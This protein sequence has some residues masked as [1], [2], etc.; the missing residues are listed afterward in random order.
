MKRVITED[1]YF[2]NFGDDEV[3]FILEND[4][5][6]ESK[7]K[8]SQM[9]LTGDS[10]K[11]STVRKSLITWIDPWKPP[12][13]V[14]SPLYRIIS[15]ANDAVWKYDLKGEW[16]GHIQYTKYIEKG[17]HYSWHQD[18]FRD[19]ED[20]DRKLSIVYSLCHTKDYKGGEFDLRQSND[21]V[22]SVK[23][24]YGDFI[25]FPSTIVHRVRPLRSGNR[26]TLVGWF[27]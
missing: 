4:A 20:T 22:W 24:D 2:G 13:R 17:H 8:D 1:F 9:G 16:D 15:H 18:N 26:T 27:R 21:E 12:F 10:D 19:G 3:T 25:V 11:V 14:S 23:F 6:I 5:E 7:K